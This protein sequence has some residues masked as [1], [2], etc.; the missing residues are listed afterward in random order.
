MYIVNENRSIIDYS[1]IR[2]TKPSAFQAK[3]T[4]LAE[5]IKFRAHI[6]YDGIKYFQFTVRADDGKGGYGE[7]KKLYTMIT[8]HDSIICRLLHR[9]DAIG[10]NGTIIKENIIGKKVEITFE[11]GKWGNFY[12]DTMTPIAKSGVNG[13]DI[14]QLDNTSKVNTYIPDG[15]KLSNEHELKADNNMY[16]YDEEPVI[17]E[18]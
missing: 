9:L 17:Y 18:V 8:Q 10:D 13:S 16:E 12:V 15:R 6:D 5:I 14:Q 11:F 3:V 2:F 4:Y 7:Y 1:K